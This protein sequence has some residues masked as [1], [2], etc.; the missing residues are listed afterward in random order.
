MELKKL[1]QLGRLANLQRETKK[2]TVASREKLQSI[3]IIFKQAYAEILS[4]HKV[5]LDYSAAH[6]PN[7]CHMPCNAESFEAV[8][9]FGHHAAFQW[10]Q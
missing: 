3:S 9:K 5:L 1:Q 10:R 6:I 7:A 4:S 2:I 8:C